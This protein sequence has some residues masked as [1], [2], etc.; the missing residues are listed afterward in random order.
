MNKSGGGRHDKERSEEGNGVRTHY[1]EIRHQMKNVQ[2]LR[3]RE[4]KDAKS[5]VVVVVEK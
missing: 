4:N 2:P 5:F 3:I 1:V